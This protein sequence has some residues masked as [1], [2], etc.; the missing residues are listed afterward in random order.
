MAVVVAHE[1]EKC[2]RRG[3]QRG[4]KSGIYV[5]RAA[6]DVSPRTSAHTRDGRSSARE[7]QKTNADNTRSLQ[8]SS[9][10]D[11]A[12]MA[13]AALSSFLFP[14]TPQQGQYVP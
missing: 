9:N 10:F 12:L 3:C 6:R 13:V 7:E 5:K 2:M 8:P 14:P 4:S 1:G 11:L